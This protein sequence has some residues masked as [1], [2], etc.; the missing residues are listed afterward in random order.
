MGPI[1]LLIESITWHGM[2]IDSNLRIWQKNEEPISILAVPYQN[3][4]PLT[5]KAAGRARNRAEWHRGGEQQERQSTA[6]NR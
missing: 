6:R 2:K 3:L 4:K 5:M 1:G